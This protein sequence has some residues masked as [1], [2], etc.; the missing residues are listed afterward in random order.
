M[1]EPLRQ[2]TTVAP[3]DVFFPPSNHTRPW[4]PLLLRVKPAPWTKASK[5]SSWPI[6]A[7]WTRPLFSAGGKTPTPANWSPSPPISP[8]ARDWNPRGTRRKKCDNR[9]QGD[10]ITAMSRI[11]PNL[12]NPPAAPAESAKAPSGWVE[13]LERSEAQLARGE[14]VP[15]EPVLDRLRATIARMEA[16]RGGAAKT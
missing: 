3:N 7:G 2:T 4:H 10:Y 16:K 13:S 14:T 15:L 12:E 11:S 8:R 5:K 1:R 9:A 6:P